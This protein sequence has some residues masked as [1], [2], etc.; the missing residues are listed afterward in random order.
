MSPCN[1]TMLRFHRNYLNLKFHLQKNQYRDLTKLYQF[2]IIEIQ[3]ITMYPIRLVKLP[4]KLLNS[5]QSCNLYRVNHHKCYVYRIKTGHQF[6]VEV[7]TRRRGRWQ[8]HL[9][10][11]IAEVR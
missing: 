7:S 5:L 9:T 6:L 3:I 2:Q 1:S 10:E 4:A 8:S 11:A